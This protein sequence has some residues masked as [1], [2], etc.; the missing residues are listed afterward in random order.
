MVIRITFVTYV[1]DQVKQHQIQGFFSFS[2]PCQACRGQGNVIDKQCKR[3]RANGFVIKNETI[4]V[5]V[6]AGVDN[7]TVIRLR[8]YGGPGSGGGPDGDLLVQVN[9]EPHKFFKRNGSDLILEI[10]LLFTEA[11]LGAVIK[12]CL[13][14]TS[15]SPRDRSISR[16][17]SSA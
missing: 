14:Y 5:K 9:V 3:C 4:K 15:P 1:R 11:A 6:P 7:G 16:M 2:Q 13:L 10:P 12:I 17:P 8:G